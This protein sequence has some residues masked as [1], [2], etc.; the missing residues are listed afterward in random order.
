MDVA[1]RALQFITEQLMRDQTDWHSSTWTHAQQA[2]QPGSCWLRETGTS[3]RWSR[4]RAPGREG[5]RRGVA[6]VGAAI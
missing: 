5:R 1:C 3:C 4:P 6:A 2:A